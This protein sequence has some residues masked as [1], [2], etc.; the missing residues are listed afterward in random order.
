MAKAG[1]GPAGPHGEP[2]DGRSAPAHSLPTVP[3]DSHLTAPVRSSLDNSFG[4]AHTGLD[5]D[6]EEEKTQSIN[7]ALQALDRGGLRTPLDSTLLV[8]RR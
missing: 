5:H 7:H 4:V 6:D 8:M 3:W 2:M 1:T